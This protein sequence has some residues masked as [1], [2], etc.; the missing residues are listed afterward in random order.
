MTASATTPSSFTMLALRIDPPVARIVLSNPPLNILDIPMMEELLLAIEQVNVR[1]D[2]STVVLSGSERAFCAGVDVA[3][4]TPDKVAGM[5]TKFH[6]VIRG[7]IATRKVTVG[8]VRGACLGGGAE[9]AMACDI[10]VTADNAKWGFPEIK[11]GCFPPVAAAALAAIV[12]QKVAADLILTGRQ[13]SGADAQAMGLANEAVADDLVTAKVEERVEQLAQLSPAALA[14]TK[15]AL[16]GWD[17]AHFDKGLARAEQ[18]YLDELMKT[19]DANEG[20]RA[21]IERRKPEW[22]G[23]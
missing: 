10:V 12:G 1:P 18:I 4:H 15:K 20:I 11:L 7:L 16:Y 3:A 21:F 19:Q 8:C 5:L 17:S 9:L 14:I 23:R 6:A 2:V 22:K 13:F